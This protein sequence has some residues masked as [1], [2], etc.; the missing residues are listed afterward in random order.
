VTTG[1]DVIAKKLAAAGCRF[2]FGI[3]GGEVLAIV[4]ALARAGIRFV[5]TR[6]ENPAGFM[7]EG[8][9]HAAGAPGILVATIG[10]GVANAVNTIAN[11]GQDRV[12]LDEFPFLGEPVVPALDGKPSLED[13]EQRGGGLAGAIGIAGRDTARDPAGR[14]AGECKEPA[15]VGGERVEGDCRLTAECV[16]ASARDQRGDVAVPLAR[17]GEHDQVRTRAVGDDGEFRAYDPTDAE[18]SRGYREAHRAAEVVVV[19]EGEGG[20][21]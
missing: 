7:A 5:L 17:L 12:P 3:P 6:H 9:W 10:P 11:A 15:A 21:A 13:V 18:L 2:A 4:D 1:A 14:A 8:V 20:H 16:H 19:G